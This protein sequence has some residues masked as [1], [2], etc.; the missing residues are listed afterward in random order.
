MLP[1]GEHP[2]DLEK[3]QISYGTL[4]LVAGPD[5]CNARCPFCI[6]RM[7]PSKFVDRKA[8][9]INTDQLKVALDRAVTGGSDTILITGNG[10]PTMFPDQITQYL[11]EVDRFARERMV[12]LR[13][14]MQTNGLLFEQ[15][16]ERYDTYLREWAAKGLQTIA[17]SVSHYAPEKNR[18]IYTPHRPDYIDLVSLINRIKGFGIRVRLT[19]VLMKGFIDSP[20]KV[21]KMIAFARDNNV[22]EISLLP[23]NEPNSSKDPHSSKWVH[24]NRLTQDQLVAIQRHIEGGGRLVKEFGFGGKVFDYDGQNVCITD[25]ITPEPGINTERRLIFYP[26]GVMAHDWDDSTVIST[27][28]VPAESPSALAFDQA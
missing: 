7:V 5:T 11:D 6:A 26:R 22:E 4:S 9:P 20:E 25:C 8:I 21:E 10:E 1:S 16:P 28:N 18:E 2:I 23:V 14:E 27:G 17:V 13:R 12:T 24:E 3:E 19:V 15:Q